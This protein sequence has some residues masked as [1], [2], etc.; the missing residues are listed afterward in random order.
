MTIAIF[1][2]SDVA[3]VFDAYPKPLQDRL[4][5]LRELIF[6][7]AL[8]IDGVGDLQETLKW[9]QPAYLTPQT[10]SGTTI[11]IDTDNKN[12]GEYALYVNCK[13]S[14]IENWKTQYPNLKYGGTR[15][16]QFA[17]DEE[18][19]KEEVMHMIAMALTYNKRQKY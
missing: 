8:K 18:L 12:G 9:D 13:T 10:K 19:P 6:E 5:E 15:S 11:R 4:L 17:L 14:L 2:N 1:Q 7:M 16:L 3:A